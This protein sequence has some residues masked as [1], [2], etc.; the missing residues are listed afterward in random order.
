MVCLAVLGV[1]LLCPD[2]VGQQKTKKANKES[3]EEVLAPLPASWVKSMNWRSIGPANMSGRITALS[4]YEADPTTFYAATASGGLLKTTNNGTSFVHQFDREEAVSIGDV[5]VAPSD[6]DVVWVG[7]GEANPRNSVSYGNGVYKSVDGGKTWKHMGLKETFQIGKILIHPTNPDIV[8]VGALGRL[9]GPNPERGLFKT[10]DGGKSWKKILYKDVNTG[11]ID[12]RMHPRDPDTL[13]VAMWERRRDAFDS[14]LTKELPE[15]LDTY[16]P[17]VRWGKNAGLYKTTN[18]GR[19]FRK[20]TKGLPS[21]KIGRIGLDWYRTNPNV[22]YAVVSCEN[23]GKGKQP[24]PKPYLGIRGFTD[25]KGAKIFVLVDSPADKAGL[26]SGDIVQKYNKQPIKTYDDLRAEIKNSKIGEVVTIT[27]L[28]ENEVKTFRVKLTKEP[29]PDKRKG[30]GGPGG[31]TKLRPYAAY[32]GGQKENVQHLQGPNAHEYGGIYR[33]DDA[34][35]SWERVNSFNPRPMYFSEIRIDP[36]NDQKVYILGI[37]LWRSVDGGNTFKSD[38]SRGIHADGHAL[39]IDPRDGRHAI[40][41]NDGGIYSTYDAMKTWNHHN[42][43]AMGQFYHVT[44]DNRQPYHVYG[45][46]QDNGSWGGPSMSLRGGLINADW[47]SIGGGDG[48]V[49]RVD[50]TDPNVVYYESQNGRVRRRNLKTGESSFVTPSRKDK[51]APKFRFNWKTPFILSHHNGH[52]L[53][54]AG[55][56]VFRSIDRGEKPRKISPEITLTKR[57]S[58][59]ALAES[60]VDRQVLWVG[61]DDG[62]VWVTKDGGDEWTNVTKRFGLKGPRWVATIEASRFAAGRAYVTFDAHRSDDDN[63]YVFVTEDYGK[64]WNSISSNLPRGSTRCLREDVKNPNLLYTGTEFGLYASTNRGKTWTKL[65]NNL[66][67]VAIHEIAVHPTAGEIVAATHGRSLWILDVT[68]LR[69]MTGEVIKAKAHLYTPQKV[70]RWVRKPTRGRHQPRFV[71]TNP[72]SSAQIFYSLNAPAK[73]VELRIFDIEGKVLRVLKGSGKPGLNRIEW[74]TRKDAPKRKKGKAKKSTSRFRV[75]RRVP[76]PN[77]LYRLMLNVD[78]K[79]FTS[80]LRIE[81]DPNFPRTKIVA[82]DELNEDLLERIR[83]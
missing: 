32:Y 11:V 2:S 69:Q 74:D 41:G 24:P 40:I 59:T 30:V 78:G 17:E 37:R 36:S 44:V 22:I 35:E 28:R 54:C 14:F 26:E 27:I 60:P 76:V 45:G 68:P 79:E 51:S 9:Y 16:D 20:I 19:S 53:Y 7:T 52:I 81:A 72:P 33:S 4:I 23:I 39:W 50:P 70:I 46:L 75:R 1:F 56:Y 80:I 47:I 77:G 6:P 38:R 13:L 64:T 82:E 71:G 29:T 15:G 12:M 66:P 49:C 58:A 62:A 43:M 65:N 83:K 55:N 61:T 73:K 34:G 3:S 63:P 57:G 25:K 42:Y 10:T 5:C 31:P 18:G 21:S 48:F 67:T 8:Y